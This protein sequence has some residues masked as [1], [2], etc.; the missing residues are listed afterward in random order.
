PEPFNHIDFAEKITDPIEGRQACHLA[1]AEW[2]LLGWLERHGFAHDYYAETQLADG[3]LDLA[4]YRVLVLAVHPEYWTRGMYDRVK[5]WGFD[6][7]GRLAYLGGN[8][9]NCEVTLNSDGTMVCHNGTITGL[10]PAAMGGR[11]SRTAIRHE[12]EASLL[13]VVFTPAGVNTGAPYHV[14]DGEHWAFAGT[15]LKTGGVFGKNCLHR[16][17]PGGAS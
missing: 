13:G 16:R 17:C 14:V 11:E 1:P 15:G 3:T 4:N 5:R 9:L 6:E 8:G 12:S 2:R 10:T 7:G